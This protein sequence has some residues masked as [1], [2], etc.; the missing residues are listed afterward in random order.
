MQPANLVGDHQF[1]DAA[2][3]FQ[4]A[5]GWHEKNLWAIAAAAVELFRRS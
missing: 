1:D 2:A 3:L 4:S 5:R